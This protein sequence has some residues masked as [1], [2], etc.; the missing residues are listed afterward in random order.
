MGL[1]FYAKPPPKLTGYDA[2]QAGGAASFGHTLSPGLRSGTRQPGSS[3]IFVM[4]RPP[5]SSDAWNVR[6]PMNQTST[7]HVTMALVSSSIFAYAIDLFPGPEDA[8]PLFI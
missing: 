6:L 2:P 3:V 7:A 4:E 1:P 5:K 8:N